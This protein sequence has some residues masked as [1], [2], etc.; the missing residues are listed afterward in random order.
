MFGVSRIDA[1]AVVRRRVEPLFTRVDDDLLGLDPQADL[2]YALNAVAARVWELLE[3]P[4]TVGAVC[5]QLGQEFDVAPATCLRD[6]ITLIG[7]LRSA[8]LVDVDT[9]PK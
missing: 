9:A 4:R 8:G 5:H 6:V 3:P 7:D 1:D 2:Y